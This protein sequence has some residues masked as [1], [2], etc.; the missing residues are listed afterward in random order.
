[1]YYLENS[2]HAIVLRRV[3]SSTVLMQGWDG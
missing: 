3:N 1:M 2:H